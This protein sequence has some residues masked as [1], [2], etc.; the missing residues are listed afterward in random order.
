M[1]GRSLYD[2]ARI[3]ADFTLRCI[4]N[5]LSDEGHWYG[6]NFES[7]LPELLRMLED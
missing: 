5:T 7:A 6:V 4:E 2:A 3:A 1:R